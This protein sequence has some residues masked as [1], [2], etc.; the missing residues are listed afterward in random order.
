MV[1]EDG[2]VHDALCLRSQ[3]RDGGRWRGRLESDGEEDH[4]AVRIFACHVEGVER[5]VN[6]ADVRSLG[7]GVEEA[8]PRSGDAH[9]VAKSGEDD[10]LFARNGDGVV[11]TPHWEDADRTAW[12]VDHIDVGRQD[13]LNAVFVD[14]VRMAAADLHDLEVAA[15]AEFFYIGRNTTGQGRI[16]VFVDVFHWRGSFRLFLPYGLRAAIIFCQWRCL[17]G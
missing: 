2:E 11:D 9:H 10:I 8:S 4:L 3:Q 7:F 5:R 1:A 14:G 16:A 12:S 17:H 6:K 15:R 13:I